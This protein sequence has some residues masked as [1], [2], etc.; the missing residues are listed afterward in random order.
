MD[1]ANCSLH[2]WF[3]SFLVPELV[4]WKKIFPW[5]RGEMMV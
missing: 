1:T 5:P 4:S 3:P 2:Q